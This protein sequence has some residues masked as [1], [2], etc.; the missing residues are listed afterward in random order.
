MGMLITGVVIALVG[1]GLYLSQGATV[2]DCHTALGQLGRAISAEVAQQ[3]DTA[4]ALRVVGG[5]AAGGGMILAIVG[6]ITLGRPRSP[7]A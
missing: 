7:S 3:C 1:L 6:A 2:A 4:N 5:L